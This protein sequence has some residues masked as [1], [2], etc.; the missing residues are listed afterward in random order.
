MYYNA[1]KKNISRV[2]EALTCAL[3]T[4]DAARHPA[5]VLSSDA[6]YFVRRAISSPIFRECKKP[7][8]NAA[9][10][11]FARTTRDVVA[12]RSEPRA[13]AADDGRIALASIRIDAQIF[14]WITR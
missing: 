7:L 9:F 5:N 12:I 13:S 6:N 8:K 3:N 1:M 14:F 4:I 10:L 2:K 11:H